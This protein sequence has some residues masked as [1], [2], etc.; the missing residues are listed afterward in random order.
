MV[1]KMSDRGTITL[2]KEVRPNLE[3]E[4][5]FNAVRREDAVIE[6]RPQ[7]TVDVSA[8]WFW[9][10]EW[11]RREREVQESYNR[12]DFTRHESGEDLMDHFEKLADESGSDRGK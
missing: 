8:A 1:I 10:E 4:V 11:Q 12:G 5:L 7:I 3:G 2:P 9:T 6:L